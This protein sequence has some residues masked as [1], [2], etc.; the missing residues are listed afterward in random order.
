VGSLGDSR[1][2]S[3]ADYI[4]KGTLGTSELTTAQNTQGK[5][6]LIQIVS[7]LTKLGRRNHE[8]RE[9]PAPYGK[10]DYDNDNE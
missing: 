8:V 1:S 6:M 5:A 4:P 3:F 9:N 2:W 7:M 10:F